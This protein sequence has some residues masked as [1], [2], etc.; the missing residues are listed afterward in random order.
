MFWWYDKAKLWVNITY[1]QSRKHR[2]EAKKD[3][4]RNRR[5]NQTVKKREGLWGKDTTFSQFSSFLIYFWS[6]G[7]IKRIP[8]FIEITQVEQ[9]RA[10]EALDKC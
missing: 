7:I 9:K 8:L 10:D 2:V 6:I 1:E 4:C 3:S 5:I